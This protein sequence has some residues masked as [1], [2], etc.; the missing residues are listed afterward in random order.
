MAPSRYGLTHGGM[1]AKDWFSETE[2]RALAISMVTS[3][4][5]AMVIASG[6]WKI[7]Q[8]SPLKSSGLL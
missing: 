7:S 5:R 3:T 4:D 6:A 8:V 1:S 2:L